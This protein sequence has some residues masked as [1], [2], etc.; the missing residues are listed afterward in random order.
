MSGGVNDVKQH[1]WFKQIL[2]TDVM[3]QRGKVR[4]SQIREKLKHSI[5]IFYSHRSYQKLIIQETHKILNYSKM[6]FFKHLHVEEKNMIYLINFKL[7]IS[8]Y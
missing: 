2:W 7:H 3:E 4:K 5:L 6:N 8:I 1:R